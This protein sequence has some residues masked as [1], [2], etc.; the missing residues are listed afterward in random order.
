DL[1]HVR[2]IAQRV[3]ESSGLELVDVELRGG[4]KHRMLRLVIDRPSMGTAGVV[5]AVQGAGVAGVVS[6]TNL[7]QAGVTHEDCAAMSREVS[8]ILDVEDAVPGGSYTLEVSSPG[9]DRKL[10]RPADFQRFTGSRVRLM[11]REPIAG[12]QHFEG[13]LESFSEGRLVLD[14]ARQK[15]KGKGQKR[16]R[17]E[18]GR[19]RQEAMGTQAGESPASTRVEI[20]LA[21]VERAY[22]VPEV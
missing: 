2:S 22:L 16:D 6:G 5:G 17:R 21:N 10:V 15:A 18:A 7:T 19:R 3:A 11:T 14:L 13:R 9:L 1:E 8:A 12:N 4:G 20:E